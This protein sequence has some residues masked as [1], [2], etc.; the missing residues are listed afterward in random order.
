MEQHTLQPA[1][2]EKAS[3]G[4]KLYHVTANLKLQMLSLM[5]DQKKK[6]TKI[7]FQKNLMWAIAILMPSQNNISF[8]LPNVMEYLH[9]VTSG[10]CS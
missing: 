1:V 7:P 2:P 3:L 6:E 5:A 8:C 10:W 9:S 4:G